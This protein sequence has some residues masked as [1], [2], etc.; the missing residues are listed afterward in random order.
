MQ[1]VTA[2]EM[3]TLDR[4]T[5]EHGTPGHVLMERAGRGATQVLLECFPRLRRRGRRA[6]IVAGKG[7]NGGDGFVIARLLRARG[8]RVDVVL[9]GRA[10]DVSGDAERQLRA[11]R[12]GRAALHEVVDGSALA[13]LRQF[14]SGADIAVDAIFGTGLTKPVRGVHAEAIELINASGVP[15]LAVDVPSGLN[16]DTGLAMGTAVQA[17][18]TA[19]FGFAK[20]GQVLY[21]GL[22]YCGRLAVVDIGIAPE[23]LAAQPPRAAL[24]ETPD[25]GRLVPV[26]QPDA[27][28]GDCGH[29]LVIAG[30]FGKTGAAQLAS[31]AAGRAGAGLVTL[32]APQSLYPIY[33]GGVLEAMTETLPDD[34]GRI[35][36]DEARLAALLEGKTAVIIGPGIGTHDGAARTVRWLLGNCELPIVVDADAITVLAGEAA[37]LRVSRARALLTPHPGEMS[38]LLGTVTAAVQSDRAGVARRFAVE[39]D[40]T[41]VLKGA[42]SVIADA[43]GSLWVNPTGN[44]GMASGGMGDVLSGILGGLLAQGLAPPEAACL[45]VYLHGAVADRIAVDG[46]VG[47]LASDLI[48]GIRQGLHALRASL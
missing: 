43:G 1:L 30:S 34:G 11:Y 29:V 22:R 23:A 31:R 2:E 7:N 33:A 36:F 37:V 24:L 3:R 12:R 40:C 13:L 20:I 5:I 15:V 27:H 48:D 10:S 4:L 18:A 26:R 21:P 16:A 28:K 17:E 8:V 38:R 46:E 47:L 44:P 19:T 35:R 32:A 25:V 41:L 45:G 39:H 6:V 9:L 14:L 42:R